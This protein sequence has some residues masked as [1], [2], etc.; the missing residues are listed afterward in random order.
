MAICTKCNES[1]P[2]VFDGRCTG[3]MSLESIEIGQAE[4][5]YIYN[6]MGLPLE[7][8]ELVK[9]FRENQIFSAEDY[10]TLEDKVQSIIEILKT[11]DP[12]AKLFKTP[13]YSLYEKYEDKIDSG[14]YHID[15]LKNY[16]ITGG[17]QVVETKAGVVVYKAPEY[18][19]GDE[20][21]SDLYYIE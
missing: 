11:R 18:Y 19:E 10:R 17:G 7:D 2:V 9:I 6:I 15:L 16:G 5:E 21:T 12:D 4:L 13:V 8:G 3:C 20:E 1:V 14:E